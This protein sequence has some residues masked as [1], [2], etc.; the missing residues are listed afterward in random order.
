M[1]KHQLSSRLARMEVLGSWSLV[2][3]DRLGKA[4]TP[5]IIDRLSGGTA[6]M[7]IMLTCLIILELEGNFFL[8]KDAIR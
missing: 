5:S 7:S 4:P 3:S 6:H 1:R 2:G 8:I